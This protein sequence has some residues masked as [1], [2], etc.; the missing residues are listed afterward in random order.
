VLR[1]EVVVATAGIRAV[2]DVRDVV[3]TPGVATTRVPVAEARVELYM[4]RQ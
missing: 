2:V 4:R 3:R 1:R